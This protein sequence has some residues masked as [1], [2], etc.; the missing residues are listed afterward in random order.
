MV[1]VNCENHMNFYEWTLDQSGLE[2]EIRVRRIQ[3]SAV[4]S[5]VMVRNLILPGNVIRPLDCADDVDY[6]ITEY[7]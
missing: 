3:G 7:M 1:N 5:V 4:R 6:G 2:Y